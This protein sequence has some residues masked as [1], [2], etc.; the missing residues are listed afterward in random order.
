MAVVKETGDAP[1]LIEQ[2]GDSIIEARY[3]TPLCEHATTEPLNGT[4]LV[5]NDGVELWH[6][7]AMASQALLIAQEETGVGPEN[8]ECHLPLVSGSFGR[9]VGCDDLRMVLAVAKNSRA[10]RFT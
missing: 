8:I 9:R 3:L 4:A 10:R 5:T 1:K 7:F 6:P 2:A